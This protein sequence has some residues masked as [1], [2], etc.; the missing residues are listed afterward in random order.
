[1]S[2]VGIFTYFYFFVGH[3]TAFIFTC[4]F[5]KISLKLIQAGVITILNNT[6]E[7]S[8]NKIATKILLVNVFYITRHPGETYVFITME[9]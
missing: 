7:F 6:N 2:Q 1:M 4:Q 8:I 9:T 5:A 3:H